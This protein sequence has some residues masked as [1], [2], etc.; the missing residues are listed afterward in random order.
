M[1]DRDRK[2]V[3]AGWHQDNDA[4]GRDLDAALAKYAAVEPR[5]GLEDRVLA[6]LRAEQSAVPERA[7][8]RWSVPGALAAVVIVA[9][10]LAWRSGKPSHP[11]VTRQSSPP[12]Q[13]ARD[14]GNPV[15]ASAGTNHL[16]PQASSSPLARASHH[17][18]REAVAAAAPKL[19]QFPSPQPLSEQ[20]LALV[21]YVSEFPQ[22]ATLIA[23][24]QEEYE[25]EIRQKMNDARSETEISNSNQPER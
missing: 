14:Q 17:V 13:S 4:L 1:A 12:A 6:N 11:V 16:P 19:D 22:E 21:R 18:R 10:A 20:E 23:R 24:A 8:W 2:Q 7:W 25:N 9:L 15:V 3:E 5:A